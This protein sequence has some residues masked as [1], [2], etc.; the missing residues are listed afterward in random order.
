MIDKKVYVVESNLVDVDLENLFV[1]SATISSIHSNQSD[2]YLSNIEVLVGKIGSGSTLNSNPPTANR[3]SC[4][5]SEE[6]AR[7]I[8]E[9]QITGAVLIAWEK[10]KKVASLANVD[11]EETVVGWRGGEK[12]NERF[13]G[14][15]IELIEDLFLPEELLKLIENAGLAIAVDSSVLQNK[16]KKDCRELLLPVIKGGNGELGRLLKGMLSDSPDW[17]MIMSF[18]LRNNLIVKEG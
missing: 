14:E 10:M 2:Y 11:L 3:K 16:E 6:E 5:L 17:D 7:K 8:F 15:F 12:I 13:V 18:V 4:L 1:A 9:R